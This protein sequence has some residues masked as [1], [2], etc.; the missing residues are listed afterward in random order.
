[1]SAIT[2]ETE[3]ELFIMATE[4]AMPE[5]WLK[6]FNEKE[7]RTLVQ[8]NGEGAPLI[9]WVEGLARRLDERGATELAKRVRAGGMLTQQALWQTEGANAKLAQ[10]IWVQNYLE[11]IDREIGNE[12]EGEESLTGES[13]QVLGLVLQNLAFDFLKDESQRARLLLLGLMELLVR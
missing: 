4:E 11:F 13:A 7:Y 10:F 6:G 1:M 9:P 5:N 12:L 8:M 2:K 3:P